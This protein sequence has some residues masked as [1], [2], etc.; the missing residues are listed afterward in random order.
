MERQEEQSSEKLDEL[1]SIKAKYQK[2]PE[3][4]K[5]IDAL[6]AALDIVGLEPS[7][8]SLADGVNALIY[9]LRSAKSA[10]DGESAQAK[11]HLLDAGISAI[12][13]IPF[14]DVIK[15]MRLRKLSK[16][17]SLAGK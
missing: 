6:Q 11:A 2:E 16:L 15:L 13:L 7:I 10:L 5:A 17:A 1:S 12:S 9:L 3:K 4:L 8:G 14:A